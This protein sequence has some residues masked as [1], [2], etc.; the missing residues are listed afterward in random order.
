[1]VSI[2]RHILFTFLWCFCLVTDVFSQVPPIEV[3]EYSYVTRGGKTIPESTTIYVT[4]SVH[5]VHNG[6]GWKDG[7]Y[8][9]LG[10]ISSKGKFTLQTFDDGGRVPLGDCNRYI[11]IRNINLVKKIVICDNYAQ[12]VFYGFSKKSTITLS[13][14]KYHE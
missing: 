1:M 10:I 12:I 4:T 8:Y 9:I 14:E 6:Y 13:K 11:I 2:S 3:F 7:H 5:K